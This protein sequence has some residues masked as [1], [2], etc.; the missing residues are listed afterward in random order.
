ML[1]QTGESPMHIA[2]RVDGGERCAE[3]LLQSG[4]DCNASQQVGY[5]SAKLKLKVLPEPQG[6]IG[7]RWSPF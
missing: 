2:A 1:F 3:I 4:A 6:P 7:R 5:I